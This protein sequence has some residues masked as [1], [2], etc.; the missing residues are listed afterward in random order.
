MSVVRQSRK[1][2]T[3]TTE[4]LSS[5]QLEVEPV[6]RWTDA[7]NLPKS[8]SVFLHGQQ[9]QPLKVARQVSSGPGWYPDDGDGTTNAIANSGQATVTLDS[10]VL[11]SGGA[12]LTP[13]GMLL[14]G[15]YNAG[16]NLWE[17]GK[18]LS[19][20]SGTQV[21]TLAS[22]L[23]NSWASGTKYHLL[24]DVRFAEYL[25]IATEFSSSAA[26]L[27]VTPYL[28]GWI[29]NGGTLSRD[30]DIDLEINGTS[31]VGAASEVREASFY[32]GRIRSREARGFMGAKLRVASVSAGSVSIWCA[33]S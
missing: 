19:W 1:D 17:I 29:A 31:V 14:A 28:F 32:Y 25:H 4:Y 30:A 3:G 21:V 15:Q 27:R 16:S 10:A 11:Q 7:A 24:V 12:G 18:V 8:P 22:N 6:E 5:Q 23:L 13:A 9:A 26:L 20:N 2:A 33:R